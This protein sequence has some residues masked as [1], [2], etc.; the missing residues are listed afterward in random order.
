MEAAG[1]S[2]RRDR[3]VPHC[4]MCV[5]IYVCVHMC[6]YIYI[7]IYMPVAFAASAEL[8]FFP[9]RSTR[10]SVH[11]AVRDTWCVPDRARNPARPRRPITCAATGCVFLNELK[12]PLGR[13]ADFSG[14]VVDDPPSGGSLSGTF[15]SYHSC[16]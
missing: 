14:S 6:I 1:A 16:L 9:L 10:T 7:Y 5:S 4:F 15:Y 8:L 13:D 11:R 3:C 12:T 2:A